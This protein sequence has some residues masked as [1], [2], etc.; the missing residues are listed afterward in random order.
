M[1]K[2]NLLRCLEAVL[3]CAALSVVLWALS[4]LMER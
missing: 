3:F 2:K 4:G 1:K